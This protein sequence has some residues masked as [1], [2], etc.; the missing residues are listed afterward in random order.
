M[1]YLGSR[2]GDLKLP[3]DFEKKEE[4]YRGYLVLTKINIIASASKVTAG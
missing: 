1:S 3:V 4:S 2:Y